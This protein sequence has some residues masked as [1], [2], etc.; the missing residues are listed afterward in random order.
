VSSTRQEI[1]PNHM[2]DRLAVQYGA[3]QTFRRHRV[4]IAGAALSVMAVVA[5]ALLAVFDDPWPPVR[6]SGG[7]RLRLDVDT[8]E[9]VVTWTT[10][11][12]GVDWKSGHEKRV[13]FDVGALSIG[14]GRTFEAR[15]DS[16]LDVGSTY[17]L[18]VSYLLVAA[19]LLVAPSWC[20]AV[21]L[22]ASRRAR[23]GQC[24]RC[25][26]D[27]RA[28]PQRCPECGELLGWGRSTVATGGLLDPPGWCK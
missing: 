17:A 25:G 8:L 14:R 15:G 5:L 11:E 20:A 23:R 9:L 16:M 13:L 28:L 22:R 18:R 26:Y 3:G 10:L 19:G 12:A 6:P 27:M 1:G 2:Q 21:H 7:L 24:L 4:L